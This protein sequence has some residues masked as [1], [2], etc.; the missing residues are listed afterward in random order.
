MRPGGNWN[1]TNQQAPGGTP[2][3]GAGKQ[4]GQTP[5]RTPQ[6]PYHI[7]AN[8]AA[9]N[10][11]NAPTPRD[12]TQ[13]LFATNGPISPARRTTAKREQ[14]A[15][16]HPQGSHHPSANPDGVPSPIPAAF[17]APTSPLDPRGG[18]A[19]QRFSGSG[20][21]SRTAA[22]RQEDRARRMT[23]GM[24]GVAALLILLVALL[25]YNPAALFMGY[26]FAPGLRLINVDSHIPLIIFGTPPPPSPTVT[27]PS[28]STPTATAQPGTATPTATNT[29]TPTVTNTPTPTETPTPSYGATATVSFSTATQAVA[30]PAQIQGCP[31]G[32]SIN[33]TPIP[34]A[35]KQYWESSQATYDYT[36]TVSWT[37]NITFQLTG[38]NA[39]SPNK[40]NYGNS[41]A[42]TQYG[43]GPYAF[44]LNQN[45]GYQK[46]VGPCTLNNNPSGQSYT[47]CDPS[48]CS[49][50]NDTIGYTFG[51]WSPN[52]V[53][54][55]IVDYN[56]NCHNQLNDMNSQG[57][58]W[59]S[60]YISGV[61]GGGT[62]VSGA[63]KT[64]DNYS[65]SPG[66][67]H[68]QA[69]GFTIYESATTYVSGGL[70]YH[71]GDA[72]NYALAALKATVPNGY[73]LT[74]NTTCSPGVASV[75]GNTIVVNCQDTGTATYNWSDPSDPKGTLA[76]NLAGKS[77]SQALALCNGTAGVVAGSCKISITGGNTNVMPSAASQIQISPQ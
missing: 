40:C 45:D 34:G 6:Y 50:P 66:I 28:G 36:Q 44:V 60:S 68:V 8:T 54:Y 76:G 14:R 16:R 4:P 42:T 23:L 2:G 69:G 9:P 59:A 3:N 39:I 21:T 30:G 31:S 25:I 29:P 75:N 37:G 24:A 20:L 67:G 58:S 7:A 12:P 41:G 5:G 47:L 10:T 70:A 61:S 73:T 52:N 48:T 33:D 74:A 57:N 51:S 77:L 55:Y 49:N 56:L 27:P 18:V 19:R 35:S 63:Q 32:C 65:C 43:C 62:V 71:P 38:C 11:P 46:D 13:P 64:Q 17:T 1:E 15:K 22:Q 72:Q 26:G 53:N